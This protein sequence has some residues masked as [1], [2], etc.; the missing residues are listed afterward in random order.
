VLDAIVEFLRNDLDIMPVVAADG[1]G[2]L[3]GIF[4]PLHAAHRLLTRQ[5]TG[6]RSSAAN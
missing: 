4:T 6:S 5:D 3:L 1:I 2:R